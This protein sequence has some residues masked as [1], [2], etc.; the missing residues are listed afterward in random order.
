VK[1]AKLITMKQSLIYLTLGQ[2]ADEML[3]ELDKRLERA[4]GLRND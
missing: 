1:A 2:L 3:R 4:I